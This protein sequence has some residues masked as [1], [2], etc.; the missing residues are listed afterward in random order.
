MDGKR[1]DALTRS[2]FTRASSRRRLLTGVA[3]SA[4]GPLAS[5]LGL[6]PAEAT[7][8]G[9]RHVGVRCKRA[10]QCCSGIC[11]NHRCQAHH[12]GSCVSGL[13]DSGT[14][15]VIGSGACG[16]DCNCHNTTGA[17][18]Y[19]GLG[20][21]QGG[22]SCLPCTK[23]RECENLTGVAGAACVVCPFCTE[24]GSPDGTGCV[25]PCPST[26]P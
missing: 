6:A 11:K 17:A 16:T 9:C 21:G 7:H 3:G 4:L 20:G 24:N 8:F 19:C 18:G 15:T 26:T 2:L 13:V 25:V 12:V 14:C 1:F 10:K 23:D 5:T 22:V